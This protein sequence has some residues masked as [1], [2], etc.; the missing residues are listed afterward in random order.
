MWLSTSTMQHFGLPASAFLPLKETAGAATVGSKQ[1]GTQL[2]ETWLRRPWMEGDSYLSF[3]LMAATISAVQPS[4][5]LALT[6]APSDNSL[7][8]DRGVFSVCG[9][10]WT[11]VEIITEKYLGHIVSQSQP[12]QHNENTISREHYLESQIW[13]LDESFEF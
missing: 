8:K 4:L 13:R 2:G 5:C 12:G 6:S 11:G 1:P 10:S 9:L 3:R 7:T